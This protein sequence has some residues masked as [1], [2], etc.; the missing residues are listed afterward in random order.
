[1]NTGD[2]GFKPKIKT[3]LTSC[4]FFVG[5]GVTA[6]G[7]AGCGVGSTAQV[8][9]PVSVTISP[10]SATV[11]AGGTQQFSATVQNTSNTAVTWQV[12]GVAGGNATVGTISSSGLYT[13]PAAVQSTT[14]VTVTAVSQ[15][16]ATKSASV[17]VTITPTAAVSVTISPTSATVAAGGTQQ[18]SATVQ[19]TSNTAVT[20]Q[21]NG[22]AG[23]NATVGTISSSGLYTAPAAVQ[24]TTT[25]TVTAVSQA[26][27]TKSASVQVTITPTAAVSVTISPTSATVAAGGTQ[28]F[29]AT[30]QNTSNTAVTWQVN[31]VAGGN[32][33][34]GTISSSGLYT[35]PAAVQST[36]TVTVTAV[37][38]ADATKSASVQVTITPTAAVS[39]TISPTSATV[40][41]GGTQQ[42]SAT[43]QNTSN[44]AVTWQ[45]NGVAG[46]NATVGTIS[47]SGLYTA[48]AA[49]QSTTT[50]T[51]TAVSQA[52]ATKSA[53]VQVTITP[54]AAVSV[55]ISPTSA[56][57]AAG[58]TQQFSATVQNTSNTAV[59]WQVNGVAGG[60]ATVGTI[61]SSGL[62]TAPAAVQ[63]TTTVTV[64]AVSQADATKSASVQVTI[65]PTAAV[66]VTI[67]PT[68]ATVAAGGT[69]QFSATV[70]NT[71]N[72]AVTWQVN[73]VAGGNATVGTISS[74]G[75]Y[76]APA[77]VQ[78]TT[79]VTVTAVSQADATKSASV[80]VTITPT[81]AVSVT[82]S[83][84]S[85]TV[86]AGG[87]QQFSATVQNTSNTAVTWQVNGVA[88]GNATVGTISSSGLYTAPAAVQSTTTVT[89]T[90]VSQADATKSASV[91]VTI[92][93]TAAVSVTISPTSATVA[94]GGTQQFS[95]TVQNTSNTAVTWQ[96]NG[97][98]GGNAT[99]GTISSAGL[100][101]APAAVQSTT[102]VT[103]TAVSQADAT[104]SA[105]AQVTISPITG[106]AFYVSTTGS[107]SNP[108]TLSSPWRTIQHA[109]NSV[110]AGD[111]VYVR[112]GVYNESVNI[113][114]SGS[115]TAGPIAFQTFPGE[116]AIVDGTG[117]VP[118]TSGTQG[119]INIANQSYISFQGFE[120]RNYQTSSASAA[121]AGIW[122]SGSGSYI[123]VLN[124]LIHNIVTTSETTGN[125]FG[126]AVYGTAAPASLDRVTISGN[127]VYNLKTG[128]SESVNVDGNVTNF[129]ITNNVIHDNDNIGIDIIG[130]EGVAPDPAYDYARNGTVSGN[131]IYN[132]AARNNPGHSQQY[133]ANGIYVDGGSQVV[134]E[135]NLI[136]DVDIGIELASEHQGRVTSFVIARNNLVYWSNSVGISI[137]GYASN[138][139]GTD[140]CTIGNNTLFQNDTKSTGSGEFQIQYY[141]TSNT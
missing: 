101:T 43:V 129:A 50:V 51:V 22:V 76:T 65:T 106:M 132:T 11:A 141:A 102:T 86:A 8:P 52:D 73:G 4:M 68:S 7:S 31:G 66:S 26:D 128:N 134:I 88:G 38:Q 72:T 62:Y 3:F 133:D 33:T 78:S 80:Q 41:A 131:T 48:P 105:S 97:V 27:A 107:D 123:Q 117:L 32:A 114:V 58:G 82:I 90:A 29:S 124:N 118:S 20:W 21:V 120:I 44:T 93:P 13:A 10:T 14:T 30:V 19:N 1:M 99:V 96:V 111:T 113:S 79:T 57:V 34:V 18:F 75:L 139:G 89:V 108:G 85:A 25:V 92:T 104:K 15:A 130:F 59:T 98:A 70:Q 115:A 63:S 53:S 127:Q 83:P 94:A 84:T 5:V 45:V 109:S 110:Q 71:S 95:A 39:V 9:I 119:L 125:A 24:S 64:T 17:Q 40:A 136:H 126:I 61:S 67:S 69:Q 87:T 140:H 35:A 77:A 46:G 56:T 100:Y 74:S 135:R 116:Q 81:A 28:Q 103:V 47:S 55:T 42:F 112:G 2:R 60:N 6:L 16:D 122:I 138:V 121:P 37:S 137:G 23:G 36:T 91:Q 12:N 49:V 54:T